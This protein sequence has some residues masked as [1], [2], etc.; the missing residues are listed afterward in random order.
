[1]KTSLVLQLAIILE[2]GGALGGGLVQGQEARKPFP[3][4]VQ[5]AQSPRKVAAKR[6]EQQVSEHDRSDAFVM[7]VHPIVGAISVKGDLVD[8]T[9]VTGV[10]LGADGL[11]LTSN[12]TYHRH[13]SIAAVKVGGR[14]MDTSIIAGID[15]GDDLAWGGGTGANA[16]VLGAAISGLANGKIGAVTLGIATITSDNTTPFRTPSALAHDFAIEAQTL[17]TI[18]LGKM[19]GPRPLPA[20]LWLD[21]DGDGVEEAGE[22]LVRIVP[23]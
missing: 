8:S 12:D 16:D 20:S 5:D 17:A 9:I 10:N 1:M 14:L 2:L 7:A 19:R 15:P 22:L 4:A 21:S 23:N 18:Q 13:A 3:D 6:S 11:F